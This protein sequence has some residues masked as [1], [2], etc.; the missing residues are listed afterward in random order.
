MCS[1]ILPNGRSPTLS[2]NT[3]TLRRCPVIVR[4]LVP[5][6]SVARY[7]S[8]A[9][10]CFLVPSWR[11]RVWNQIIGLS[12]NRRLVR[13]HRRLDLGQWRQ[14]RFTALDGPAIRPRQPSFRIPSR[15][16]HRDE[17][18][19]E[20]AVRLSSWLQQHP[21]AFAVVANFLGYLHP[22]RIV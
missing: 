15:N 16:F 19:T 14:M 3:F 21:A 17:R 9:S 12:G 6:S 2:V 20:F 18:N 1:V 8:K 10:E 7:F 5:S 13:Q 11:Q 4:A 22:Y